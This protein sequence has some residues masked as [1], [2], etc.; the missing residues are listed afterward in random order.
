M[1]PLPRIAKTMSSDSRSSA[2]MARVYSCATALDEDT[3][4]QLQVVVD[5]L[6]DRVAHL[7]GDRHHHVLIARRLRRVV[8]SVDRRM[9]LDPPLARQRDHAQRPEPRPNRSDGEIR[10]AEQPR[11]WR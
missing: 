5:A 8:L 10:Q 1:G 4:A 7:V 2:A 3:P 11:H 6:L 9:E